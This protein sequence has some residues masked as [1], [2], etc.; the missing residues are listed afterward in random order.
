MC[1][2]FLGGAKVDLAALHGRT[3][4][5]LQDGVKGDGE[6]NVDSGL[7]VLDD[8]IDEEIFNRRGMAIDC[9]RTAGDNGIDCSS[10]AIFRELFLFKKSQLRDKTDTKNKQEPSTYPE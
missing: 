5:H 8:A 9:L 10:K 3:K 7:H 1:D 2:I 4:N 6:H